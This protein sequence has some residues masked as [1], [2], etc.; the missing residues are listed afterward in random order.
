MLHGA[1]IVRYPQSLGW[2]SS[3][4]DTADI[5][6]GRG[7]TPGRLGRT[8]VAAAPGIASTDKGQGTNEAW[9]THC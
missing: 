7:R 6:T 2:H 5:A 3:A 9:A 1:R 8:R 4:G